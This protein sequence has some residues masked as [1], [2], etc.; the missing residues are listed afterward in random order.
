[1]S[2]SPLRRVADGV[3]VTLRVAPGARREGIGDLVPT[4]D[5]GVALKVSVTAV[6]EDGRANEAV[7]RLLARTWKLP[8]RALT[9]VMGAAD[10]TKVVHIAGGGEDVARCLETWMGQRGA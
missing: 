6:A 5:G 8:R 10:R 2:V 1:M 3:R 7:L 9:L 4:V